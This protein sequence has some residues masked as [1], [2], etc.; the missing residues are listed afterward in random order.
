MFDI[1]LKSSF[2]MHVGNDNANKILFTHLILYHIFSYIHLL[3]LI[4]SYSFIN[5]NLLLNFAM[6]LSKYSLKMVIECLERY[7]Q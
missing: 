5:I 3:T 6:H 7:F 1:K 2:L 4:L